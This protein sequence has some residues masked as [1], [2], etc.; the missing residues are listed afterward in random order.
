MEED[1]DLDYARLTL[2]TCSLAGG[3]AH[4]AVGSAFTATLTLPRPKYPP[5]RRGYAT[6]M[7]GSG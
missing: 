4:K 3:I 7:K 2:H 1:Y 6:L 5:A